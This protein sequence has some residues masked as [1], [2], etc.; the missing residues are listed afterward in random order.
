MAKSKKVKLTI[1]G[2]PAKG[3][4]AKAIDDF[5]ETTANQ[6][7][8]T[9]NY[10]VRKPLPETFK[11]CDYAVVF[12]GDGSII[13]A[14]RELAN[15]QVPVIG[16]NLGKLGFLAEFNVSELTNYF[17]NIVKGKVTIEKR[18]MLSCFIEREN[19]K[20]FTSTAVNDI[21]I[22]AGPPYRMVELQIRVNGQSLAGCVSDGLIIATPTGSTAYNLSAG[23]PILA[24]KMKAIIIN[25]ICPHSLNFRPIV[26]D[27]DSNI[28]IVGLKLNRGTTLSVDG[29]ISHK[30]TPKDTITVETHKNKFLIVNNPARTHW[31]TLAEKLQWAKTPHYKNTQKNL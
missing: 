23:G 7:E 6:A 10:N 28:D 30:V 1:F 29:Q 18:M 20:I 14:A 22:N 17:D 4:V 31:D 2:D 25:P 26:I 5:L 12:G 15:S 11:N 13:K 19:K 24:G 9:G 8:I 3:H 16:V 27:P 21:F